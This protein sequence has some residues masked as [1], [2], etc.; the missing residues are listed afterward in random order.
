MGLERDQAVSNL[1]ALQRQREQEQ[2]S[3]H[4]QAEQ[5]YQELYTSIHQSHDAVNTALQQELLSS[6]KEVETL[7]KQ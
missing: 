2:A 6:R 1:A 7:R 5:G 4:K 3:L